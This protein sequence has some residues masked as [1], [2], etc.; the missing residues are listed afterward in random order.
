MNFIIVKDTGDIDYDILNTIAHFSDEQIEQFIE[1]IKLKN[2]YNSVGGGWAKFRYSDY[3]ENMALL[4]GSKVHNRIASISLSE[5]IEKINNLFAFEEFD[6]ID[7]LKRVTSKIDVEKMFIDAL[8]NDK[9]NSNFYN[10]CFQI[11][12]SGETFDKFLNYDQNFEIFGENFTQEDYVLELSKIL[13][14]TTSEIN[15]TNSIYNYPILNQEML[16]RY[17]ELRNI[18]NVDIKVLGDEPFGE[19][20]CFA[21]Y[22]SRQQEIDKDWQVN[23]KLLNYVMDDMKPDYTLLDKVCHIYIKLCYALRY[24]NVY[25]VYEYGTDYMKERQE[26]ISLDNNEVICSE[27]AILCAHIFNQLDDRLEARC[28]APDGWG[29]EA[30]GILIRDKNI[31]IDFEAINVNNGFNDLGRAKLGLPFAG[32]HYICDRNNEFKESF[33]KVYNNFRKENKV[34][35]GNLISAYEQLVSQKDFVIDTSQNLTEFVERM[36]IKNVIGNELL[37]SFMFLEKIGYFGDIKYAFVGEDR[38][39]TF[40]E[41]TD[42]ESLMKFL[43]GLEENIIICNDNNYYLLRLNDCQVYLMKKE[44]LNALFDN[45]KMFYIDEDHTIE[46]IRSSR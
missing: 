7:K 6:L 21:Y 11:L 31:R 23:Q 36:R 39:I 38:K 2:R 30:V 3:D 26:A 27:F 40:T 1:S 13:G 46:G 20:G 8:A 16:N 28:V 9:Y 41:R 45:D 35:T 18:I 37:N 5:F 24:S 32:I 34:E 42:I 14:I 22:P 17:L 44:A 10:I 29:H 19:E 15:N 43:D 12:K 33:E 25:K 4:D